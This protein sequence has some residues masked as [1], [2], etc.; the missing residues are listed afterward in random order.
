[1]TVLTRPDKI[2]PVGDVDYE[3]ALVTIKIYPGQPLAAL[4]RGLPARQWAC[5][6]LQG[7]PGQSPLY[8]G[9]TCDP[10]RRVMEHAKQKPWWSEVQEIT[11]FV[12][13]NE[14]TARH[15]EEGLHDDDVAPR[16]SQVTLS[17]KRKLRDLLTMAYW[18][19]VATS[20]QQ[21]WSAV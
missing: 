3:H 6:I 21:P 20:R 7:D 19:R 14:I 4:E 11:L 12:V 1:M 10:R 18:W 8:I 16:Y 15:M 5:Y 2:Y 17:D 9:H 13:A